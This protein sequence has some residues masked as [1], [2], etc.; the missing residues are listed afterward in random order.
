MNSV[1]VLF[2]RSDSCYFDLVA[3]VWCARRDARLYVGPQPVVAHPPCRAWGRFSKVAAPRPDEAALG[4]FAA[5]AVRRWG[6]VL[7]HPHASKL[8]AAALLPRPG[9]VDAFGGFTLLVDQGWWGHAAPKPTWLYVVGRS[10]ASVPDL[11]VQLRR[12]G[13]RVSSLTRAQREATPR[14]FAEFLV[15]LAA[16]CYVDLVS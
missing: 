6:G 10:R 9:C 14:A 12:A 2:A 15:S 11:P 13:G 8:W 16:G 5:E 7:E 1:S 3:D 4:L